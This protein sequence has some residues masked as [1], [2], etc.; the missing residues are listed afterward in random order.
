MNRITRW[1]RSHLLDVA[2][3]VTMACSAVTVAFVW[4]L[5][6]QFDTKSQ[7][8]ARAGSESAEYMRIST[9]VIG[10]WILP[11]VVAIAVLTAI[12][13]AASLCRGA[14]AKPIAATDPAA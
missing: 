4:Y 8:L 7:A 6:V 5:W 13:F 14:G 10:S 12:T 9:I 3:F 2:A 11:A 1:L